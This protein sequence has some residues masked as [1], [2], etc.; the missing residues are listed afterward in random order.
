MPAEDTRWLAAALDAWQYTRQELLQLSSEPIP[1]VILFDRRCA[2]RIA[3][4]ADRLAVIS[5][6][7]RGSIDLPDGR[8]IEPRPLG[9]ASP[10]ADDSTVFLILALPEVWRTDPIYRRSQENWQ[11]YLTGAFIHEMTHSRMLRSLLPRIRRFAPTISPDTVRDDAVQDRFGRDPGFAAS[12]ARETDLLLR[13]ASSASRALRVDF[14]RAALSLIRA[15]RARYF[16][17]DLAPWSQIEQT[18]LD[19]EGVAQWAAFSNERTTTN[20]RMTF[21]RAINRFRHGEQYWSQD[22]GLALFLALDALVPGW[23]AR[24]FSPEPATSLDLLAEAVE[25]G[26]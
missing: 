14:A 22:Q 17:G 18:F 13:A 21:E 19:L 5:N 2:Y 25:R 6:E 26:R 12:V 23:Q 8:S 10:T 11:Q 9:M 7:H 24:I 4:T 20:R 3:I 16:V 1:P 15:R